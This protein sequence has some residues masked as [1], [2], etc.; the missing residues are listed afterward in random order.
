[1]SGPTSNPFQKATRRQALAR[2]AICGPSGSGKSWTG[3]MFATHL[4]AAEGG[5]AAVIDTE[6]GSAA[7]YGNDFDFDSVNLEPPFAPHRYI[8]LIRAAAANGYKAIL[9]DSL[10]HGWFAEG[11]VLEIVDTAGV[12]K[13][14]NRW[15]GWS[16]GTPAQNSLISAILGFPGHVVATMRSKQEWVIEDGKPRRVGMAPV[17]RDGIEFEFTLV[18]DMDLS[19]KLIVSK[20][21]ARPL[22]DRAVVCPGPALADDLLDW[23]REGEESADAAAVEAL[24]ASMN[25]APADQR[26]EVKQAFVATFGLPQNLLASRLAEAQAWVVQQLG[27]PPD[28]PG[29]GAANGQSSSPP[30]APTEATAEPPAASA[31]TTPADAADAEPQAAPRAGKT[32]LT[33]AQKLVLLFAEQLPDYDDAARHDVYSAACGRK[34]TSGNDLSVRERAKVRSAVDALVSGA[35]DLFYNEDGTPLLVAREAAAS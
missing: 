14:G 27:G 11:G 25:A 20:S 23:L 12:I 6:R 35:L 13:G 29:P 26:A 1:M 5:R 28:G 17:Q 3:L 15:A 33:E 10:S 24:A 4:A 18:G 32:A 7:L 22:A 21:R 16:T 30:E 31:A 8:E 34:V 19:H 2:V 9:I